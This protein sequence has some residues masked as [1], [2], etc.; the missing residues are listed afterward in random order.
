MSLGWLEHNC[1]N[2]VQH[3]WDP[4]ID[5]E[6]DRRQY[7]IDLNTEHSLNLPEREKIDHWKTSSEF[8]SQWIFIYI[9]PGL[10]EV[11]VVTLGE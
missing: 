9:L 4:N 6:V 7:R 8:D 5:R 10:T 3:I 11:D 2:T 1:C